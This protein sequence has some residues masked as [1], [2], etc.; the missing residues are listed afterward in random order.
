MELHLAVFEADGKYY[1]TRRVPT[2][3]KGFKVKS[4]IFSIFK[5]VEGGK[6]PGEALNALHAEAK[7]EARK[8]GI[9]HVHN[10]D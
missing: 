10:L 9:A 2:P 5:E 8:R 1:A 6:N 7:A 4:E 3:P